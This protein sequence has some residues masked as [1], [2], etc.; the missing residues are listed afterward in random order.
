MREGNQGHDSRHRFPAAFGSVRT[1][2][3]GGGKPI[4][5][6]DDEMPSPRL[7]GLEP[8][9]FV[10]PYG[11]RSRKRVC[12]RLNDGKTVQIDS[13][14]NGWVTGVNCEAFG[15]GLIGH[16]R[17][18]RLPAGGPVVPLRRPGNDARAVVVAGEVRA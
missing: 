14:A 9:A 16:V 17:A 4:L 7:G 6:D 3:S 8:A 10:V 1:A 12:K 13:S 18:L 15:D 5:D 11:G 2:D